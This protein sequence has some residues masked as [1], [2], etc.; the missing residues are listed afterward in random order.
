MITPRENDLQRFVK[1]R[2]AD[3]FTKRCNTRRVSVVLG[4][5]RA[6]IHFFLNIIEAHVAK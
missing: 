5:P 4:L 2:S 1:N 3:D 6:A